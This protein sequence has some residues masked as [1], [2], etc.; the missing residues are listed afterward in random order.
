MGITFPSLSYAT[1]VA[2]K[3]SAASKA[4]R[5][6]FSLGHVREALAAALGY[7]TYAALKASAGT[8]E[9]PAYY[10]GAQHVVIDVMRLDA[11]LTDLG[12]GQSFG[13]VAAAIQHAF[14]TLLP[15]TKLHDSV[16]DLGD[17]LFAEIVD[18]IE[19][20]DGYSSEQAMTNAYG[21]DFDLVFSEPE[22][23]D[24][25]RG[26][27]TLGADGTS[28]LEQDPDKVFHGDT[29]DVSARIVFQKIGRRVLGEMSID[30]AG[31]SIQDLGEPMDEDP[32]DFEPDGG[33]GGAHV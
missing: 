28:S 8:G 27:W 18:A 22:P 3:S 1:H 14:E 5:A 4:A 17:H 10:D 23:I 11:R 31:G 29:L 16:S 15:D 30:E 20:S 2:I 25:A 12:H 19:N 26:E 33:E 24:G 9:E 21:G 6:T 7:N 32:F 13:V